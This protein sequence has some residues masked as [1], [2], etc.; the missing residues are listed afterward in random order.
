M[1]RQ[2]AIDFIKNTIVAKL[3]GGYHP[4]NQLSEYIHVQTGQP[5]F[6]AEELAV[7]QPQH[8]E[9]LTELGEYIWIII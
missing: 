8:D 2:E 6:T 7:L 1:N 4:D 5:T 3:G 9:A